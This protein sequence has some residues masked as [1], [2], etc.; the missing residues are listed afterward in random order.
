MAEGNRPHGNLR[1][2]GFKTSAIARLSKRSRSESVEKNRENTE[3]VQGF[4]ARRD[5]MDMAKAALVVLLVAAPICL[6]QADK[7]DEYCVRIERF[8]FSGSV[9][10]AKDGRILLHM[11]SG[12]RQL[13]ETASVNFRRN[14]TRWTS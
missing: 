11:P 7:L 13:W 9:L 4:R 12:S 2:T 1:P 10:V 5:S 8:G 3:S 14:V 6:A